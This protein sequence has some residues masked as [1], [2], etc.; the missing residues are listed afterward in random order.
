MSDV[1]DFCLIRVSGSVPIAVP[2]SR[3]PSI[4]RTAAGPAVTM[5]SSCEDQRVP[6][7]NSI[8][9]LFEI[10][11]CLVEEKILPF[12]DGRSLC[13]L[14]V[15]SKVGAS[16]Q[17]VWLRPISTLIKCPRQQQILS[18]LHDN[19]PLWEA[20][21]HP[22][23]TSKETAA[24][25]ATVSARQRY[26]LRLVS[27]IFCISMFSPEPVPPIAAVRLP[28]LCAHRRM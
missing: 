4:G 14:A 10:L 24:T 13:R 9:G 18:I 26:A 12:L 21:P 19:H 22:E 17:Y 23:T 28:N 11:S 3:L 16:L 20:L 7:S 27:G 8:S 1:V 5:N 15:T 6:T 2:E 25:T